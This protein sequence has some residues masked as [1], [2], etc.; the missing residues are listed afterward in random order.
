[1]K[2]ACIFDFDGVMIRSEQYWENDKPNVFEEI[3]GL[4]ISAK[5]SQTYGQSMDQI[6]KMAVSY[7]S[8]VKIQSFYDACD[9][10]AARVYA[11]APM[12]DGVDI[13]LKE[14]V[15]HHIQLGIVS[16]SPKSWIDIAVARLKNKNVFTTIISLHDRQDLAHK[17]APDGYQEAM[18]NLGVTPEETIVIEDSNTG[19]RSAK[20]S[21]AFTIG[22]KQNLVSGYTIT[23]A[24]VYVDKI[25]DVKTFI[26]R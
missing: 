2:K 24:D 17:P 14:L 12:T 1:M 6:H 8:L 4:K 21:G 9:K 7:G 19:I 20:A 5:L 18:R 10:H 13:L 11:H 25:I 16:A 26:L 22:L 23:G 3:Y 15:S